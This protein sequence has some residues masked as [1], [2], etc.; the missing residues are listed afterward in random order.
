MKD[1][2]NHW[3]LFVLDTDKGLWMREDDLQ[4][5]CFCAVDDELY[6]IT[7][8]NKLVGL[9]GTT[10]A[11][12]L[13]ESVAWEAETGILYYAYPDMKYVN[14]YNFRLKCSGTIKL[15]IEYDSSG[16]W[17]ESGT[18]TTTGTDTVTIPVKPRRCDHMRIKLAG[19]GD[20]KLYSIARIL[21][22]G[23]DY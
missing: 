19:T 20:V 10:G 3:H 1:A 8:A 15:Y 14:R 11:L 17:I 6:V 2:D 12:T 7:A 13:E 21:E 9:N 18:I 5:K 16:S 22:I 4:A 23:S